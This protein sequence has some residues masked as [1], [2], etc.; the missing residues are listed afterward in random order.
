MLKNA[1][2]WLGCDQDWKFSM[3]ILGGGII[4]ALGTVDAGAYGDELDVV[5]VEG[6]WYSRPALSHGS[7][8]RTRP[9]GHD[10]RQFPQ[11]QRSARLRNLDG[12]NTHD[13]SYHLAIAGGL[14]AALVLP[15]SAPPGARECSTVFISR[16]VAFLAISAHTDT[17]RSE[18]RRRQGSGL[19]GRTRCPSRF[20]WV[21]LRRRLDI[22]VSDFPRP[23]SRPDAA[24]LHRY[25]RCSTCDRRTWSWVF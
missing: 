19:D 16:D 18:D 13:E 22:P 2:L 17:L 15:G 8:V 10:R 6:A 14:T 4:K 5:D 9:Y 23:P 24:R 25:A 11:G 7:R 1:T 20:C 3:V 12:L 21:I